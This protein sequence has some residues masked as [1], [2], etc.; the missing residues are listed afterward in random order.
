MHLGKANYDLSTCLNRTAM[1]REILNGYKRVIEDLD[2]KERLKKQECQVCYYG[3]RIGGA[4]MT[5]SECGVCGQEMLF[6]NTNTDILCIDPD[7]FCI[8]FC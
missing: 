5:T 3:S 1:M 6:G 2:R 7:I 4:A 8:P